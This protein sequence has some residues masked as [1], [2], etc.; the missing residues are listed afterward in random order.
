MKV[1]SD[2]GSIVNPAGAACLIGVANVA[3]DNDNF[4]NSSK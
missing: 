1:I 2:G 3:E 4:L